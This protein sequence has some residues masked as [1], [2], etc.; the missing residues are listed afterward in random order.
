MAKHAHLPWDMV[1]GADG[2][3][4]YKPT[5]RA[6]LHACELLEVPPQR[7]MLVAAHGY[8]LDTA[9]SCEL[10][11]AYIFREQ[12]SNPSKVADAGPAQ[13]RRWR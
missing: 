10:K 4:S 7:A 11:T 5:P 1:F 8:D 9:R 2:S 6:Y 3:Q 13:T 12:A